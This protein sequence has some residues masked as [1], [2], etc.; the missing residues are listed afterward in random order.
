MRTIAAKINTQTE[1]FLNGL[2]DAI[3]VIQKISMASDNEIYVDFSQSQFVSPLF[4]LPLMVY[5]A[6]CGK[7]VEFVHMT[8]YMEIIAMGTGMKPDEMRS[9]EF[10]ARME[11]YAHK[12]YIPIVNFPATRDRD[13]EKN[14][15]L[16]SVESIIIRQSGIM[17]N[18]AA[19]LKYMI[20]ENVDNIIEHSQSERG[21][22]FTQAYPKKRHID[23]C[24]ADMGITLLGSY[25]TLSDNEIESDIEAIQAASRGISTKNLPKAENR[26]YG[27]ITSKKMLVEGLKGA[28]IMISGNAMHIKNP[29]IHRF[30]HLPDNIRWNGTIIAFR[31]P[32]TNNAFQYVNYIE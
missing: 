29:S 23:I 32:Y 22:I 9:S 21:Y 1:R 8:D 3:D 28:Y 17:P 20:E 18:V 27:I 24:I 6:G 26:G 5:A 10:K 30:Y 25:R 4:V 2:E 12:T 19:G 14:A 13:D 11:A 31:I 16:S 15:I 7:K